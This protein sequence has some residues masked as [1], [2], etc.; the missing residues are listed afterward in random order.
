MRNFSLCVFALLLAPVV[1]AV[2]ALA[3]DSTELLPPIVI[4]PTTGAQ[5]P[6]PAPGCPPVP[7]LSADATVTSIMIKRAARDIGPFAVLL[8]GYVTSSDPIP[9]YRPFLL[10]ADPGG[11][12][13]L[14]FVVDPSVG[15]VVSNLHTH[16]LI[17]RPRPVQV[18]KASAP[19]PA[20]DY[21]F[22]R[23]G[24]A[25]AGAGGGD[26]AR[27]A[28]RVDIPKTVPGSLLGRAKPDAPAPYPSGLY[29]IHAHLHGVA[30]PQVTEPIGC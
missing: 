3:V 27:L 25:D 28:Y 9:S 15:A 6:Q 19:C 24:P 26:P 10:Q 17:V 7:A 14:D 2:P 22:L 23:T 20:G 30:R 11:S 29:W 8:D 12:M 18:P 16:G 21:I 5:P 1:L 13:V 4:A